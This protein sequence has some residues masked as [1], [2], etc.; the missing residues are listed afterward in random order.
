MSNPAEEAESRGISPSEMF[1]GVLLPYHMT[2]PFRFVDLINIKP[3]I[4]QI[5]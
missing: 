5:F 4:E 3:G 2:K 1:Y